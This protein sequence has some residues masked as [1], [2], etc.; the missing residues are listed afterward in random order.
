M[1]VYNIDNN[2]DINV[3]KRTYK[4]VIKNDFYKNKEQRFL[5]RINTFIKRRLV[6]KK[7]KDLL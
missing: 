7:K 6:S 5:K 2:V 4:K 3:I 1:N